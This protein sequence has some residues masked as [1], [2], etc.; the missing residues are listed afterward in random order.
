MLHGSQL[1]AVK[2]HY[3]GRCTVAIVAAVYSSE[4]LNSDDV[5]RTRNPIKVRS[6]PRCNTCNVRAMTTEVIVT[7]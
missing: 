1:I 4:D 6:F 3:A 5:G 2:G 7:P